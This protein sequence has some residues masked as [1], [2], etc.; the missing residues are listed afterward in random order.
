MS[1]PVREETERP[2][3]WSA[4]SP[5]TWT[6]LWREV[7]DTPIEKSVPEVEVARES[8]RSANAR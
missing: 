2:P 7:R 3:I 4:P 1:S 6:E 8:N 5:K